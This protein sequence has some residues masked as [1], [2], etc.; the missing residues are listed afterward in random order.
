MPV[1][2]S[3]KYIGHYIL[4]NYTEKVLVS[5]CVEISDKYTL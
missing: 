4:H 2:I 1:V 5:A 3:V